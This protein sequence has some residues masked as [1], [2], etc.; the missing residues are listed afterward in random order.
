ME[1]NLEQEI[2]EASDDF[3]VDKKRSIG[4]VA[5]EIGV[6]TH[7]I[8]FWEENFLQIKPEIGRG[9]RRYYYNK[10][11]DILKKIK[12]F[13][14]ED[15]YTIAGLKKMLQKRKSGDLQ[16]KEKDL[17]D[18]IN[19]D[20]DYKNDNENTRSLDFQG[21]I[22]IDDF[23]NKDMNLIKNSESTINKKAREEIFSLARNI[24]KNL[25][26]LKLL[27]RS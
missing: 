4:D 21:Q 13:L 6:E 2:K 22:G 7:V 5:S 8:R 1:L 11:V 17:Q 3:V 25:G 18:I 16:Q 26:D 10:Q 12:T 24:S 15:G 27:I 14:Y 23:I 19:V 20:H 9:G